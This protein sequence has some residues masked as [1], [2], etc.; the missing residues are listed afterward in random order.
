MDSKFKLSV[1]ILLLDDIPT[2]IKTHTITIANYI[3]L[4]LVS[5]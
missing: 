3:F 2:H 5:F 1:G 4:L